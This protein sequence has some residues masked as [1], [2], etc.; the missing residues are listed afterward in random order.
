MQLKFYK[1][2]S[3]FLKKYVQGYYFIQRGKSSEPLHYL[4]FPNNYT[5][6]TV[7]QNASFSQCNNRMIIKTSEKDEMYSNMVYRYTS[8]FEISYE[9]PVNEVTI[10]FKPLGINFFVEDPE[11]FFFR[12]I[13]K[14]SSSIL[15]KILKRKCKKS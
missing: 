13:P 8:P 15:L 7:M 14:R 1:P 4:T 5:I 10:Y 2:K 9:A 3:E 11:L 12:I 6:V